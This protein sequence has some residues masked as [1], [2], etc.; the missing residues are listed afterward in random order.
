M[1]RFTKARADSFA[2]NPPLLI[3]SASFF[4]ALPVTGLETVWSG[5]FIIMLYESTLFIL[6]KSDYIS[7]LLDKLYPKIKQRSPLYQR[8][9]QR[10]PLV[11]EV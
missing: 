2:T 10:S 3:A 11:L 7:V 5:Y 8:I 9:K 6:T 4:A 1:M